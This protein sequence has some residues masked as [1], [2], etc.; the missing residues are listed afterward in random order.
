MK[1]TVRVVDG[2]SLSDS[3]I[4]TSFRFEDDK[5]ATI[6]DDQ[7]ITALLVGE[8]KL[9]CERRRSKSQEI[10]TATKLVVRV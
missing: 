3:D 5:I 6:N 7:E 10:V 1:Y 9:I 2:P 4:I 8:T